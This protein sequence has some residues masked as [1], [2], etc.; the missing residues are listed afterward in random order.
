[1]I[2][3]DNNTSDFYDVYDFEYDYK[4]DESK[5]YEKH[6]YPPLRND[7]FSTVGY[8]ASLEKKRKCITRRV[9]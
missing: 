9:K 2:P 1:M 3:R 8:C 4:E 5:I 6:D 7:R